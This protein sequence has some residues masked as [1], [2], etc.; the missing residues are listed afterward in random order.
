MK[1]TPIESIVAAQA[2]LLELPLAA[3]HRPG[4]IAYFALATEMARLVDGLELG[5]E[6]ESGSVFLPVAPGEAG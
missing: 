4:V 6:D 2:S 3:E 1:P 5:I